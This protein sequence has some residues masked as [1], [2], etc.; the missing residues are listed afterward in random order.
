MASNAVKRFV[1]NLA[2]GFGNWRMSDD[3]KTLYYDALCKWHLTDDE[4]AAAQS[5][6]IAECEQL[7][8]LAQIYP[9]LKSAQAGRK[10]VKEP[11]WQ[12]WTDS[13]GHRQ[14]RP[15]LDPGN[16]PP[17]PP[18]AHDWCLVLPEE[19][20]AHYEPASGEEAYEFFRLGWIQRGGDPD[21]CPVSLASLIEQQA[22]DMEVPF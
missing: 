9:Y 19:L 6:I 16:P 7:P 3:T 17:L 15:I 10:T 13:K 18:D 1:A 8:S 21:R 5:R 14:A 22:D 12:T 20:Q 4:W 11:I 2:A